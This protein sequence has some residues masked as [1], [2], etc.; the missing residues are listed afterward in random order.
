MKK[1]FLSIILILSMLCAFMP[2]IANAAESGSCGANGD[3]VTWTLDDEGTL[4]IS[5]E[6]DMM[7]YYSYGVP[8][9]NSHS[10]I[11]KIVIE[12]GIT[13]IGDYALASV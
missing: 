1:K 12:Q 9:Y 13:S 8:W 11:T 3:N 7:D 2:V 6:G 4:T 10:N 5:G